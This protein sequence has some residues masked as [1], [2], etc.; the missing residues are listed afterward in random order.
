[1]KEKPTIE[2][3][4]KQTI[5]LI[6]GYHPNEI[7]NIK[8]DLP[9][10]VYSEMVIALPSAITLNTDNLESLDRELLTLNKG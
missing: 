3:I 4:G 2:T 5:H 10:M 7:F 6:E 1:M 8:A 9:L